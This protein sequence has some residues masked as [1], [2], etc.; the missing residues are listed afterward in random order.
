MDAE[1]MKMVG[2]IYVDGEGL[3]MDVKAMENGWYDLFFD[4]GHDGGLAP[5]LGSL[6]LDQAKL[7]QLF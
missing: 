4:Q 3:H 1:A 6:D 5:A 7:L 2:T